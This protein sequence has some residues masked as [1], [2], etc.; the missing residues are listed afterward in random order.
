MVKCESEERSR[1]IRWLA[2]GLLKRK[3]VPARD[4]QNH[5]RQ[6]ARRLYD[7]AEAEDLDACRWPSRITAEVIEPKWHSVNASLDGPLDDQGVSD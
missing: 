3:G 2:A 7:A 4:F 6:V 1:R 5:A